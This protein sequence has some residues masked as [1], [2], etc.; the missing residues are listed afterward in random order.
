MRRRS[1]NVAAVVSLAFC[2]TTI[3]CYIRPVAVRFWT[4][5]GYCEIAVRDGRVWYDNEPQR[6]MDRE[7][8][9]RAINKSHKLAEESQSQYTRVPTNRPQTPDEAQR[10]GDLITGAHELNRLARRWAGRPVTPLVTKSL[11]CSGLAAV[12][13]AV[14]LTWVAVTC[15]S[16]RQRRRLRAGGFCTA[17]GY[18]LRATPGVCPECGT[19]TAAEV[20]K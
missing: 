17:C 7:G 19:P 11:S 3:I 20:T 6:E 5:Q 14:P 15:V 9:R 2:L 18:D 8:V 12:L 16:T 10:I 1:F 13:A 4:A